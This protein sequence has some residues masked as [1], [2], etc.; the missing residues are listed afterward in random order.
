M[1]ILEQLRARAE[2]IRE[3]FER[4][5]AALFG[6]DG[7]PRFGPTAHQERL[8]ALERERDE[9]LDGLLEELRGAVEKAQRVVSGFENGD[10]TA[11]L[12]D[13]EL[14]TAAAK[15]VFIDADVWTVPEERLEG[16]LRAI[17]AGD[18]RGPPPSPPGKP[19]SAATTPSRA[20]G[21]PR[22]PRR[23]AQRTRRR[24]APRG[25][26]VRP[27]DAPRGRGPRVARFQPPPRGHELQ[28]RMGEQEIRE[29]RRIGTR[30]SRSKAA[31]RGAH[32]ASTCPG[33]SPAG[34]KLSPQ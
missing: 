3:E 1:T 33:S 9:R 34:N 27:R 14:R 17:L 7:E 24:G 23:D 10:P 4:A 21:P 15:K 13:E 5:R 11:L 30:R 12:S 32:P 2:T 28:R 18:D 29:P 20:P 16:K 8:A 19:P 22:D 26:R 25:G 31:T 6:S